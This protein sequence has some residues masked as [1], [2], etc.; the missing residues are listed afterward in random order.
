MICRAAVVLS[1]AAAVLAV[2]SAS[3]STE[4]SMPI[5]I[6]KGIG[7]INLGMTG[8]QVRRALGRP[9]TVVDRRVVRGQPYVEL[10]YGYGVW[11]VGLLG[12]KGNRRVVYVLTTLARHRTP[13]GLGVGSSGSEVPRRFRGVRERTCN[14]PNTWFNW[15]VR[16]GE[17]ELVFHPGGHPIEVLAVDVRF[18]PVLGCVT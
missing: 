16:Q 13:Q 12:R 7:P 8:E 6:G 5:R 17:T 9:R 11:H 1:L 10:E 18:A 15:F 3:A 4:A 2:A 14:N